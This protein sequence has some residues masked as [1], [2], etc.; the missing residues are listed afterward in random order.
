[1][2]GFGSGRKETARW[3]RKP[4]TERDG[5]RA[6]S[7]LELLRGGLLVPGKAFHMGEH[8]FFQGSIE[9]LVIAGLRG[10]LRPALR[11]E[12][13]PDGDALLI[14]HLLQNR[15]APLWETLLLDYTPCGFGGD[16]PWLLCPKCQTRRA[17]LY[18]VGSDTLLRQP[19]AASCFACRVCAGMGYESQRQREPGRAASRA[20]KARRKIGGILGGGN[21]L[22]TFPGK[23]KGMHSTTY[24]R[25]RG[26]AEAAEKI[27]GAYW[28]AQVEGHKKRTDALIRSCGLD[29]EMV[30]A[31]CNL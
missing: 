9:Q 31:A 14:G 1:M 19:V 30:R 12:V 23:R 29:P 21:L 7:A 10:K 20:K 17:A 18:F 2:G 13:D 26:E 6:I 5:N 3:E 4:T 11:V 15:D 27:V 8:W 16:R 25:L 28:T 22:T 24:E